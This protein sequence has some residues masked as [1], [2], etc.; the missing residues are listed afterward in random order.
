MGH[1]FAVGTTASGAGDGDAS[2]PNLQVDEFYLGHLVC[3]DCDP[4]A[5]DV[6]IAGVARVIAVEV[7]LI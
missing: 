6:C 4:V 1:G 3:G 2:E 7:E 5:I